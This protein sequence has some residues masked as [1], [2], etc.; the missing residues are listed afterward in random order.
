MIIS[1]SGT[2]HYGARR[3]HARRLD[4]PENFHLPPKADLGAVG[5]ANVRFLFICG[6][7][8]GVAITIRYLA[9]PRGI[10]HILQ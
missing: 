3:A 2:A 10:T 1:A 5:Q 6:I 8:A 7:T 4:N 9:R